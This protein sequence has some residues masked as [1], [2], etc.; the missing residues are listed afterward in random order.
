MA[1]IEFGV[2]LTSVKGVAE[3]ARRAEQLG[4]DYLTCGEHV[5][6]HGPVSNSLI[7]LSVAAGATE[8]LKLM[9]SIVLLPLYNPV[10]LAKQASVLDVASGGRYHLGVGIGGEFPKEFEAIGVPVKQRASRSNEAL[11]VI[12]KLWTEK[13]VSFEGR[14]TRFSGVTLEPAPVQ[15]PRPPI[16]VAG[17]KEPAMRRAAKY[18]DGWLPYMYTPEM[19]RESVAKIDAFGREA[20]RDMSGFRPGLFIFAAVY[21]DRKEAEEVAARSLGKNYAQDFSKIAGRYVLYG[22]PEDCR[23]RLREYVD[24]GARHVMF[25]WACRHDDIER[26]METIAKEVIPAFR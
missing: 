9:S 20:G 18:A 25:S 5:M 17:R 26:N 15:K 4:Y 23:K 8:K 21:P 11:E 6:F 2:A 1:S 12:N 24:A 16:W 19:L 7:A 10:M 13:N 14:Y 22:S 3:F